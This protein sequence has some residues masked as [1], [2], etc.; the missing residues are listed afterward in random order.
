MKKA[1]RSIGKWPLLAVAFL[2]L[3]GCAQ[4]QKDGAPAGRLALSD[5]KPITAKYEPKSRGGNS[6]PYTVLGKTYQLLPSNQGYLEKGT[7]S[8]Y[9]TKFHGRKTANGEPYD[10][11]GLS[12]A[13]RSL[14]IPTY[15]K[16]TN[17]KNRRSVVVRVNDRGPFH[18]ERIIDLSYGAATM[19][20]FA[21]QGTAP[22]L[23]ESID[24]P[25]GRATSITQ[26][27][28]GNHYLQIGAYSQ[29]TSA[30]ALQHRVEKMVKYPVAVKQGTINSTS[31]YRV[32]VGPFDT[33]D[34]LADAKQELHSKG[35]RQSH[36]APTSMLEQL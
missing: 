1:V 15:L 22:V 29:V 25:E 9:G 6:N 16:V 34:L 36:R 3:Y 24:F 21:E 11:R 13:H 20:G 19:L 35:I 10:M 14:P 5:I 17:L 28:P 4:V 31:L 8:W 7:A 12:A 26:E 2:G 18:S 32:Y 23:L 30:T 33:L 27:T